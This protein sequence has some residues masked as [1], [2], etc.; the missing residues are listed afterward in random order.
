MQ[1]LGFMMEYSQILQQA[2]LVEEAHYAA[3]RTFQLVGLQHLAA[4]QY[5]QAR[6]FRL[7][8]TEHGSSIRKITAYN[9]FVSQI[10][11]KNHSSAKDLIKDIL[12]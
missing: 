8:Q 3:G 7:S 5:K 10:L 9:L 12:I 4:E 11:V 1:G 6:S 2:G